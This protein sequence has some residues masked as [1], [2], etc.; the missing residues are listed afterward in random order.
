MFQIRDMNKGAN[1]T[2]KVETIQSLFYIGKAYEVLY[3]E[4]EN[5]EKA[6]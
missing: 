5:I 1:D 2:R 3:K 4:N 6:I